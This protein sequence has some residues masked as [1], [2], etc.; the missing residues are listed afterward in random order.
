M[1]KQKKCFIEWNRYGNVQQQQRSFRFVPAYVCQYLHIIIRRIY[2]SIS[3]FNIIKIY[4]HIF[5]ILFLLCL[6]YEVIAIKHFFVVFILSALL[7]TLPLCI[8]IGCT[9]S[10]PF[11]SVILRS[12]RSSTERSL[13]AFSLRIVINLKWLLGY[14]M[15]LFCL[16]NCIAKKASARRCC[17]V[18]CSAFVQ[19]E[20]IE[21]PSM[22]FGNGY[23]VRYFQ[24]CFKTYSTSMVLKGLLQ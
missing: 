10:L 14:Y 16:E 1:Q 21:R 3:P 18:V 23:A 19:Q 13:K 2:F 9:Y 20:S 12:P 15:F 24:A 17:A 8:H 22:C 5:C 11:Q 6:F 7:F 4:Y